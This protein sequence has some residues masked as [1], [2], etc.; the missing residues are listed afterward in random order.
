M[1]LKPE[2]QIVETLIDYK[3]LQASGDAGD[4]VFFV[5]DEYVS[6]ASGAKVA[7]VL[8]QDVRDLDYTEIP[9]KLQ[10]SVAVSGEKVGI[11]AKGY[12]VTD[13][14]VSGLTTVGAD[15][16]KYGR[17]YATVLEAVDSDGYAKIK[18]ER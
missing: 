13:K 9:M 18:I 7:G 10:N 16:S 12:I 1:A 5:N 17:L 15:V 4:P 3:L 11:L 6:T 8:L 14:N 2:R